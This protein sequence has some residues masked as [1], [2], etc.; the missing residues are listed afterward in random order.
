MR[1]APLSCPRLRFRLAS[2]YIRCMARG[3]GF[4]GWQL[5]RQAL[6]SIL[7]TERIDAATARDLAVA[8]MP[9][10]HNAHGGVHP[11]LEAA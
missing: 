9:A 6:D 3:D 4:E 1:D 8:M 7:G 2:T 5:W 11:R 10:V